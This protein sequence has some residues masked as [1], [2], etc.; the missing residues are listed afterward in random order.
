M[1]QPKI[2]SS[3]WDF[4]HSILDIKIDNLSERNILEEL[5]DQFLYDQKIGR[6]L[7]SSPRDLSFILS[8]RRGV[9]TQHDSQLLIE[10]KQRR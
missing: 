1:F 7:N 9:L 10:S 8:Q 3:I 6:E 5:V 2:Q 4:M